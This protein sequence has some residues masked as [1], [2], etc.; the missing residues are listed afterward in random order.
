MAETTSRTFC[1]FAILFLFLMAAPVTLPVFG[2]HDWQRIF[3]CVIAAFLL[4]VLLTHPKGFSFSTIARQLTP[5][6]GV[7][8]LILAT[9]SVI[10]ARQSMWALVELALVVACIGASVTIATQRRTRGVGLD[11]LLFILAASICALKCIQFGAASLA[12]F[13]SGYPTLDIDFLLDGF[14]N[15]RFYGQFQTFTLPL[16]VL[17]LLSPA[18]IQGRKTWAL[19]LLCCWWM[20]AISSGTRGTWL[21]MAGAVA[22]ICLCGPH[23]RRWIGWQALA[24]V[25]G[26]TLY[27]CLFSVLPGYLG[28][29]VTN[30]A[31]DR[32][33]TS[34]SARDIIWHQAWE[35]IKQRPLLGY[36]PMHFADIPNS[37]AAH[38][39]QAILQWA[40]EWG[41]PSALL[42]GWLVLRGL[43]ATLLLIRKKSI[44]SE[45]VDLLRLC[46]FASLIGA[47]TQSMV[48]GVIVMPYSQLWLAIVAGWL[49]GVHEY[50]DE[51]QLISRKLYGAWL[52]LLIT[53]VGYLG[54]VVIRDSPHLEQRQQAFIKEYGGRFQPRF[55]M[56]GVIAKSA[57]RLLEPTNAASFSEERPK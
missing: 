9:A 5:A 14:S 42:V 31:G 51:P 36:G 16:L 8:L 12:A 4:L 22:V 48:D 11:K 15:K 32:L 50:R 6:I 28:I 45:P 3:E 30:F 21:G 47:L 7:L 33:S 46:L 26:L 37:V 17:P 1:G 56:Q 41:I 49:L 40:S 2:T 38:P 44:S 20:I 29:E 52:A 25:L 10:R 23:G 39:H 57:H 13:V 43:W 54:Y 18:P 55:W 19:V 53:A 24:A 35:M 34:L 27:W